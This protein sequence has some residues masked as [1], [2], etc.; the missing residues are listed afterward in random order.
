LSGPIVK[1]GIRQK[2]GKQSKHDRKAD[3][4]DG[5]GTHADPLNDAENLFISRGIWNGG[6]VELVKLARVLGLC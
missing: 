3:H 4:D 5:A 2:D 6:G 1:P